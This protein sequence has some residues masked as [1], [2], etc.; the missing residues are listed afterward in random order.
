MQ[1]RRR[2]AI[3]GIGAI[4]PIGIT[5]GGMWD[6]LRQQR[7]AIRGVTRFDPSPFRSHNAAEVRDFEA[8]DFLERKRVKRLDRFG[9]FSVACAKLAIDDAELNLAAENKERIGAMM[10]SAL[11]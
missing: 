5:V 10:G 2:V 11:G 3:T 4:T 9:H 1:N 8:S 7:S 6:G